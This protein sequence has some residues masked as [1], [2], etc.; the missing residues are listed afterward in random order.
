[1]LQGYTTSATDTPLSALDLA[2]TAEDTSTMCEGSSVK[3]KELKDWKRSTCWSK[4]VDDWQPDY[5]G[6]PLSSSNTCS[7][8]SI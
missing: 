2:V 3:A 1:M 8:C 6:L 7:I 5:S 4:W